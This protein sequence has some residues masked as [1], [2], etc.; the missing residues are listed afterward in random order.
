MKDL[1]IYV[2][3]HY[4][5]FIIFLH[6]LSAIIW[7]GGM[8]A[9]RFAVHFSLQNID[10]PII[11]LQ[12]TLLNLKF[13]FK[14]VIPSIIILLA[15]ALIMVLAV[16]YK[17]LNLSLFVHL[18]ESIWTVMTLVF[19]LIYRKHKKASVAFE[20]EDFQAVK[21]NLQPIAQYLIPLNIVLGLAALYF[22][23]TLRGM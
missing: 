13:F 1:S 10:T 9:I 23:I 19:I 16:D 11:K 3:S 20:K 22:G 17:A 2:F 12:T 4:A 18:K 7:I 14:L 15:T 5:S 8:I 6:V 21:Q